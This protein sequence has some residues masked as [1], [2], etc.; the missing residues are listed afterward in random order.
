MG[1]FV[2]NY[3]SR[4]P[5]S[6][7]DVMHAFVPQ[8]LPVSAYLA[9]QFMVCDQWYASAPTQT[10]ANRMFMLG[11]SPGVGTF[12]HVGYL[13]DTQYMPHWLAGGVDLEPNLLS[14]LDLVKGT[15][16]TPNWKIYFHDY[17]IAAKLL[18]YARKQFESNTNVNIANY[19]WADY[20]PGN[21]SYENPLVHPT[22]TFHEDLSNGTLPM[23]SLIEPRYTDNAPHAVYGLPPNSNH[24]GI[25]NYPFQH[26]KN[27]CPTDA[28]CGE[29]LLL[30]IYLSLR[31]SK[32]W[33]DTLLI[34]VYDE[35]GGVYDHVQP[36]AATPPG[37]TVP[38]A[39]GGFGWDYF[40]A[41]VPAIIV[42][43]YVAA[44][45]RL[46]P[47]QQSPPFDHTS[48]I[49][50]AWECFDLSASG[51]ASINGRDAVAPSVLGQVDATIDN[52]PDPNA[53]KAPA[54]P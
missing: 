45:S 51:Q 18:S 53:V 50:S 42:S 7:R 10:F 4:T 37:S 43:K 33:D 44:G 47:P 52:S 21:S 22:T 24:P 20:P 27:T 14:Q 34:V 25:G 5:H 40:G 46:V 8:S 15:G 1:G 48:I 16:P 17:A 35:H 54:G 49:A 19:N 9:N 3:A 11:A 32:Y 13:D 30:D 36:P 39:A 29:L 6:V 31:L 38:K 23:F 2:A 28:I 41:R 26:E 12:P